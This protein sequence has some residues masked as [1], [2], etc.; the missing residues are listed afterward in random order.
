MDSIEQLFNRYDAGQLTRR[1]LFAALASIAI[2]VSAADAAEPTIGRAT[3]LNHVTVFVKDVQKSVALYQ[4][5]FAMPVLTP[6]E[7]GVNLKAGAGFLGIYPAQ[8]QQTGINH[9]CLGIENFD[10]ER[11]LEK[12][13]S[14]GLNANIRLRGDTKEL[15]FTDPD[16]LRVQLQD[17]RYIGGVGPLGTSHPK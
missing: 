2:G 3:Q 12:L 14:A 4:R 8:N 11:V 13:K 6:Q 9:F 16:G 1:E 10:A 7:P 15:Y 5:L 17:A